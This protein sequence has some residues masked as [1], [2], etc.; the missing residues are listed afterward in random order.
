[1]F[2]E[3]K[4]KKRWWE[5]LGLIRRS[6]PL[7]TCSY[8]SPS[9]F[10]CATFLCPGHHAENWLS[11]LHWNVTSENIS[12][13]KTFLAPVIW[14]KESQQQ[15]KWLIQVIRM[16][17]NSRLLQISVFCLKNF[18]AKVGTHLFLLF[19]HLFIYMWNA[20]PPLPFPLRECLLYP[21]FL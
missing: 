6:R 15:E 7:K 10:I 1:M 5:R 18:K 2:Q 3:F 21:P 12:P 9:L 19:M 20:T 16:W 4:K 17:K 8:I 14:Y 11:P 13:H